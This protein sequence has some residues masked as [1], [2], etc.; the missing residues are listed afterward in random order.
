MKRKILLLSLSALLLAGCDGTS[1]SINS[2]TSHSSNSDERAN[3]EDFLKVLTAE[4]GLAFEGT[5]TIESGEE[6]QVTNLQGFFSDDEYYLNDEAYGS[7]EHYYNGTGEFEGKI[8]GKELLPNNTLDEFVYV[9][10]LTQQPIDFSRYLNPIAKLQP[11]NFKAE[12]NLFIAAIPNNLQTTFGSVFTGY[13]NLIFDEF[14]FLYDDADITSLSLTGERGTNSFE[15]VFTLSTK[16]DIN[17]PVIEVRPHEE[18]H[19]LLKESFDKLALG[20]YTIT[21][22]DV[23][24]SGKY[25]DENYQVK[26]DDNALYVK[27]LRDAD[28]APY[29]YV[30]LES[31]LVQVEFNDDTH[32]AK[33]VA[34]P[35]SERKL[36]DL[37]S[38]FDIAPELFTVGKDG[39]TFTTTAGL[40]M[41]QYYDMFFVDK[42]LEGSNFSLSDFSTYSFTVNGDGTYTVKYSYDVLGFT[43]DVTVTVSDVGTT[44]VGYTESDYEE[45]DADQNNW[46]D[47][48]VSGL[49][50]YLTEKVGSPNN[51]PYPNNIEGLIVGDSDFGFVYGFDTINVSFDS[52]VYTDAATAMSKYEE[53]LTEIGWVN[54]GKTEY[55]EIIYTLTTRTGVYKISLFAMPSSYFEI[56]LFDPESVSTSNPLSKFI[57]DT[58]SNSINASFTTSQTISNYSATEED[59]TSGTYG[60]LIST[61]NITS[62]AMFTDNELYSQQNVNSTETISYVYEE[63]GTITTYSKTDGSW[64]EGTADM[65]TIKDV[66]FTVA[67]LVSTA[68]YITSVSGNTYTIEESTAIDSF[69]NFFFGLH[70]TNY[71]GAEV[72]LT[73]DESTKVITFDLQFDGYFEETNGSYFYRTYDLTATLNDIGTT[74]ITD[75]PSLN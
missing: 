70:F 64:D 43:G 32:V 60:Q 38:K 34:L 52:G 44:D 46:S 66:Y 73:F 39:K 18:A 3:I 25:S 19:D 63:D 62:K 75:K 41:D 9:D 7:A 55:N 71:T 59:M 27:N 10:E 12:D 37:K 47:L 51:L 2:S 74:I 45:K 30:Q 8:V 26:V 6:S 4:D 65:G 29:G 17:V 31:G 54:T 11:S 5:L 21:Y 23:D 13:S 35:D 58:F 53:A 72:E 57:S 56:K 14:S 50:A 40:G 67:D 69:V 28:K 15:L 22:L 36:S 20:N 24:P 1:S 61:D 33:G 16:E 49:E 68:N 48:N 42:I